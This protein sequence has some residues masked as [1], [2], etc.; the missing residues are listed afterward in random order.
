MFMCNVTRHTS[1]VTRY[2]LHVTRHTSHVTRFRPHKCLQGIIHSALFGAVPGHMLI[3]CAMSRDQSQHVLR[4]TGI[5]VQ[6][7]TAIKCR[8]SHHHILLSS[9]SPF[10]ATIIVTST[11]PSPPRRSD[12]YVLAMD[13]LHNP[14]VSN[15]PACDASNVCHVTMCRCSMPLPTS[16]RGPTSSISLIK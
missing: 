8:A 3:R 1:H 2:T 16:R 10:V 7:S 12:S 11:P 15:V 13:N 5:I 6:I 14:Q 4:V 9:L